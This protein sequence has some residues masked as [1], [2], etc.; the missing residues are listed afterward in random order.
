MLSCFL[1]IISCGKEQKNEEKTT[2]TEASPRKMGASEKY[3]SSVSEVHKKQDFMAED[4]VSF[5]FDLQVEG[6]NLQAKVTS[7]TD[8][9]EFLVETNNNGN[10]YFNTLEGKYNSDQPNKT[11]ETLISFVVCNYHLFYNITGADY[12]Y[13]EREELTFLDRTFYSVALKNQGASKLIP[14]SFEVFV[15]Q[16]TNML[17][18]VS[19]PHPLKRSEKV[20]LQYDKFITVNRIP[21]SLQWNIY[22]ENAK[23]DLSSPMGK[24]SITSIKYLKE[25][26]VDL[27]PKQPYL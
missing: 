21:V 11:A 22:Q 19:L 23:D 10:F 2:Q 14:T 24:V 16:R 15:E 20:F 1:A 4:Y 5:K 9:S 27:T 12:V 6:E 25:N 18:G 13:E 17:K 3:L 8:V 7:R 26:Q